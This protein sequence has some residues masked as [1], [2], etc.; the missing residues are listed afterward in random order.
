MTSGVDNASSSCL[1]RQQHVVDDGFHDLLWIDR[2]RDTGALADRRRLADQHVEDD[3]VDLVV[4]A[5]EQHG[6]D[7]ALRLPEAVDAS[8][9]LFGVRSLKQTR[10]AVPPH[11]P[12]RR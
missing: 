1:S 4:G 8:L 6:P 11:A 2:D 5:V 7:L 9:A 3:L 10:A 12:R